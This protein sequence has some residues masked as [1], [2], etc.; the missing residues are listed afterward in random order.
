[1]TANRFIPRVLIIDDLYGRSRRDSRNQ[2]R[3]NL[4]G[5]FLLRDVT[6]DEEG[7]GTPQRVRQPIAE[8]VFARGQQPA[9]SSVG[10]I[11]ENDLAGTIEIVEAR[12]AAAASE[13]HP[14][15]LVLLDLCFYTGRVTK[16]SDAEAAGMPEG[17]PG[18]DDPRAYFGLTLLAEMQRRF[19]DLP[20]IIL[21]SKPRTP[22]SREFAFLGALDFLPKSGDETA[23]RLREL[24][25][26][27]GLIPDESGRIVGSSRPLLLALRAARRTADDRRNVL[28]RGET[29][30]G[31]ELLA[32]YINRN[33][34]SKA[35][36]R[37]V[38]VNAAGLMPQLYASELFGHMRGAFTGA[39]R[40]REGRIVQADGG[41]LFLDEIASMPLD[42]QAGVLRTLE[43]REVVPVG[44]QAKPRKID[45]RFV[46]ATN[47]DLEVQIASGKFRSD[48]FFRMREAGTIYLPPLRQ[49]LEDLP[50]LVEKF[51]QAAE[52]ENA[53]A[54]PRQIDEESLGKLRTFD[55]PG[56]MREL[57]HCIVNAVNNYPGV[58][59]LAPIHLVLEHS[60]RPD[61]PALLQTPVTA[62]DIGS[63]TAVD[64]PDRAEASRDTV[65]RSGFSDLH[66]IGA[67]RVGELAG[68]L[69][70][71]VRLLAGFLRAALLA[72]TKA[73]LGNP[74][75]EQSITRAA[76][77]MT[78]RLRLGSTSAA[79]LVKRVFNLYPPLKEELLRDPTLKKAYDSA[80]SIRPKRS[81]RSK[82]RKDSDK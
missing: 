43:Y 30:T 37:L 50:L 9:C 20:V 35:R 64:G 73:S 12:W 36:G 41:D 76:E 79:D 74:D 24:I 47:M 68:R 1:M 62:E 39:D 14:W 46:F 10:D 72:T 8:A 38:C 16:Q 71:Q 54:V 65:G 18:D 29:G 82:P 52:A 57:R 42:V 27:H 26:M 23:E 69:P 13:S 55:W 75:G 80:M 28:I 21:S 34:P 56:N 17:R 32:E 31:K 48:L 81:K 4:C 70:D 58:E 59:H 2:E 78:G 49:R 53:R 3:A 22:A 6:G 66:A 11:V 60:P 7:K 63:P 33:G 67:A 61:V 19:P 45:V 40:D 51:V 25:W 15:S 77:L 44:P 5:Q